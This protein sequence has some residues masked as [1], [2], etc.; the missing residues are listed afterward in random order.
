MELGRARLRQSSVRHS[1]ILLSIVAG[2]ASGPAALAQEGPVRLAAVA[3]IAGW[4]DGSSPTMIEVQIGSD[5]LVVGFLEARLPQ[6][7]VRQP[8]EVPAGA[9]KTYRIT[10]PPISGGASVDVRV[11]SELG[12][13]PLATTTVKLRVPDRELLVGVIGSEPLARTIGAAERLITPDPIVA[14]PL[15]ASVAE[16]PLAPLSYLISPTPI[17]ATPLLRSWLEKGGRLVVEDASL[18]EIPSQNGG[19]IGSAQIARVGRGEIITVPRLD[20]VPNSEWSTILRPVPVLLGGVPEWLQ[21]DDALVQAATTSG[22]VRLPALPWLLAAIAGF[23]LLVGPVNFLILTR[24]GKR[25]LAW[26]TIPIISLLALGGF[27]IAGRSNLEAVITSHATAV[28]M[29]G[30]GASARSAVVVVTGTPSRHT[31]DFDQHWTVYPASGQAL[32]NGGGFGGFGRGGGII[33]DVAFADVIKG[34]AIAPEVIPDGQSPTQVDLVGTRLTMTLPRLG[35]GGANVAWSP[36]S[37]LPTVVVKQN[38]DTV[39][40]TVTPDASFSAWGLVSGQRVELLGPLKAGQSGSTSIEVARAGGAVNVSVTERILNL[41]QAWNDPSAGRYFS[42]ETAARALA[43][44]I[45]RGTYLFA[46]SDEFSVPVTLNGRPRDVTGTTMIVYPIDT[47]LAGSAEASLV[48]TEG[49]FGVEKQPGIDFVQATNVT[50]RYL[51]PLDLKVAPQLRWDAG[52]GDVPSTFEV[53]DWGRSEFVATGINE[54]LDLNRHVSPGGEVFL[55]MGTNDAVSQ[56]YLSPQ[57][58][59]L[60]WG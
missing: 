21:P 52:L 50:S 3:G 7:A 23:A 32:I 13:T 49:G 16:G 54:F 1:I 53:F 19:T 10:M 24:L 5:I 57:A 43:P 35:A 45:G 34:G 58:I 60:V 38:G 22:D 59:S 17:S 44:E 48:G 2:L 26:V 51:L 56:L 12:D 37:G 36:S 14:I 4:V 8:I 6:T 55:R 39:N 29:D 28:V 11:F 18:L 31:V 42:I 20:R 9:T 33:D 40:V 25:D 47:G 41:K 15:A 27:W 46:F 30:Q